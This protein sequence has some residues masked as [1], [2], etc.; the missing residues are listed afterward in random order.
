MRDALSVGLA[1]VQYLWLSVTPILALM[2]NL[3][4]A[5]ETVEMF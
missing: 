1:L 5:Y 4:K 2:A 3:M